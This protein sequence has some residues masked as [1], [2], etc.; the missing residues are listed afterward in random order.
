LV[1]AGPC[2]LELAFLARSGYKG[3]SSLGF[4]SEQRR[5]R[6]R[7]KKMDTVNQLIGYNMHHQTQ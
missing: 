7:K 2:K 5:E 6:E 1:D 3:F 4:D